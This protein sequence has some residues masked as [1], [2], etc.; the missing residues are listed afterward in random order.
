MKAQSGSIGGLRN[1]IVLVFVSFV[2]FLSPIPASATHK[3]KDFPDSRC[4]KLS[5]VDLGALPSRSNRS[6]DDVNQEKAI[7]AVALNDPAIVSQWPDAHFLICSGEVDT[8][9]N[10]Y[11]VDTGQY[12]GRKTGRSIALAVKR[13]SET[14]AGDRWE[15]ELP[16]STNSPSGDEPAW[17]DITKLLTNLFSKLSLSP[18]SLETLAASPYV[19]IQ[20]AAI[21]NIQDQ[22][23]LAGLVDKAAEA[24]DKELE[25]LVKSQGAYKDNNGNDLNAVMD[26]ALEQIH[27]Q[28]ILADFATGKRANGHGKFFVIPRLTD[29]TVLERI[30]NEE[31]DETFRKWASDRLFYLRTCNGHPPCSVPR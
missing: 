1:G 16:Y 19:E 8:G 20:V 3:A 6:W 30:A 18:A 27:D 23:F 22:N 17:T 5:Q 15:S 24:M 14:L 7:I 2:I 9:A 4:V 26:A 12:A 25:A 13:G 21:R 28:S 10:Y 29:Q 31:K 11:S